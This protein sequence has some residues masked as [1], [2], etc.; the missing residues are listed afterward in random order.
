MSCVSRST[1][2]TKMAIDGGAPIPANQHGR[3]E[4]SS[5]QIDVADV[6][7]HHEILG[8]DPAIGVAAVRP[9]PGRQLDPVSFHD[10]VD[11]LDCRES[12]GDV[13]PVVVTAQQEVAAEIEFLRLAVSRKPIRKLRPYT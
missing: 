11:V 4:T 2:K 13:N 6:N 12:A 3:I 8:D 7:G 10:V 9:S 5:C 1:T